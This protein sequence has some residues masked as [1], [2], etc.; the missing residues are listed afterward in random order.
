MDIEAL[1]KVVAMWAESEPLVTKAYI[2]GSRARGDHRQHSDLDVAVEIDQ[3]PG[4][5]NLL[6]T[7]ICE[8]RGLEERLSKLIPYSLQMEHL[9]GEE[10]PTVLRGINESSIL[11]YEK[12]GS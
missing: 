8:K 5:E 6:A 1:K 2:F 3:Q 11:V 10:T 9:E 12:V 4:D 7:W